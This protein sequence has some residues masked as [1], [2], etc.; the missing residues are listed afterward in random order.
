MHQ[1]IIQSLEK[2]LNLEIYSALPGFDI[3]QNVIYSNQVTLIRGYI[4]NK[5]SNQWDYWLNESNTT[6]REYQLTAI[7]TINKLKVK[8]PF[9]VG[10]W[11][12]QPSSGLWGQVI[13]FRVLAGGARVNFVS[14]P[15]SNGELPDFVLISEPSQLVGVSSWRTKECS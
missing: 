11:V 8:Q 12:G 5:D 4:Y 14:C 1:A 7:K 13:G 15:D 10:S 9:P 3:F 6:A 2:A